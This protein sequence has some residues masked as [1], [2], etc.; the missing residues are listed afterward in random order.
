MV[1]LENLAVIHARNPIAAEGAADR[2][3][4]DIGFP[5]DEIWVR[6]TGP[7]LAAHAGPGMV[8]VLAMPIV[9]AG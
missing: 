8:A 1:P 5:R 4:E 6:E 2:L 7:A 9:P 3:A